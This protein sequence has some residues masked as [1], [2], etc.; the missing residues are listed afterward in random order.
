MIQMCSLKWANEYVYG[1]TK[2][3]KITDAGKEAIHTAF[4]LVQNNH[5]LG[6]LDAFHG[7][8]Y[9]DRERQR[10]RRI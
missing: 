2:I 7:L 5:P 4:N 3:Y 9:N 10:G 6:N 8:V 1:R